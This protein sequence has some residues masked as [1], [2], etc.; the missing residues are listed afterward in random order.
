MY[1]GMVDGEGIVMGKEWQTKSLGIL[2]GWG[3]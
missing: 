2:V 1:V 3:G